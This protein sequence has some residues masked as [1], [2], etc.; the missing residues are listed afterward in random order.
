METTK[1]IPQ[2][3]RPNVLG[4][5]ALAVFVL[6][7][8][9]AGV[10][11]QIFILLAEPVR[12]TFHLSDTDFGALQGVAFALFA[13]L[14]SIPLGWL[15][16]R[17]DRRWILVTCVLAWSS[18][19]AAIGAVDSFWP[20][21]VATMG[22]GIGEAGLYPVIYGMIPDLFP[23][24]RQRTLANTL[25]AF[26][27]M[28]GGG[29]GLAASGSLIEAVNTIRPHLPF[30]WNEVENWRIVFFAAV[31]L[32]LGVAALLL[33]IRPNANHQP[34]RQQAASRASG[35]LRF[36]AGNVHTS[37]GVYGGLGLASLCVSPISV[38]LPIA[39]SRQFGLPPADIGHQ[40]GI[41]HIAGAVAGA[42]LAAF[43]ERSMRPKVGPATP[44]RI[45][46]ASM[47]AVAGLGA[48]L[49]TVSSPFQ[50][51]AIAGLAFIPT[52][53]TFAV[54][55]IAVQDMVPEAIRSRAMGVM[56]VS[57]VFLSAGS[58]VAVGA[59]SDYLKGLPNPLLVSVSVIATAGGLMASFL[60]FW[61]QRHYVATATR[62]ASDGVAI[63]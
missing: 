45:M 62:I 27:V 36:F 4:W 9:C 28:A 14:A 54:M 6:T 44:I 34:A 16:D 25:F 30:G 24:R 13:G 38:W 17:F 40:L 33:P 2:H 11:R 8:I 52:T 60:L 53:A 51:F 7:T 57:L 56:S 20:L 19:T 58:M 43:L 12:K 22:V 5:Y 35:A 10:D 59:V 32:G 18:L 3:A 21:F 41:A 1:A 23:D 50:L 29:L 39:A 47:L 61:V 48:L 63:A 55:A 31:P 37:M 26:A 46:A 15:A 42:M 49:P